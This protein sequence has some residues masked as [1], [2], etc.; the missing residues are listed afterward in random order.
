MAAISIVTTFMATSAGGATIAI[1]VMATESSSVTFLFEFVV[2]LLDRLQETE[3]EAFG[4]FDFL[5]GGSAGGQLA[6]C[7]YFASGKRGI[8]TI[9]ASTWA[10]HSLGR[11]RVR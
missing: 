2:L 4:L 7:N 3:A 10:H 11:Y 9:H 5:G 8:H 1:M 6:A